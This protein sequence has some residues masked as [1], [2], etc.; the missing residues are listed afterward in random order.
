MDD[1]TC[2][3]MNFGRSSSGSESDALTA[4]ESA[5]LRSEASPNSDAI[6]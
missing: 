5:A 3:P 1:K 2:W 6:L 4:G